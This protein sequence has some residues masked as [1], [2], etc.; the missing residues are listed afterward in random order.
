VKLEL[1]INHAT[2]LTL[3]GGEIL[4]LSVDIHEKQINSETAGAVADWEVKE[5]WNSSQVPSGEFVTSS[6][7]GCFSDDKVIWFISV[8]D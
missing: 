1:E 6:G 2:K 7:P 3:G 4:E 5:Q 8:G